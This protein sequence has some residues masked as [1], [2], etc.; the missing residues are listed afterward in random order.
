MSDLLVEWR[1]NIWLINV[2][3]VNTDM[4][5]VHIAI[6]IKRMVIAKISKLVAVIRASIIMVRTV[7]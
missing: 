1:N 2:I 4:V 5:V 3:G 7:N 6:V